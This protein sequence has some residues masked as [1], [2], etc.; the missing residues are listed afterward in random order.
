MLSDNLRKLR[1]MGL[2]ERI[3]TNQKI[4][5][6]LVLLPVFLL[7]RLLDLWLFPGLRLP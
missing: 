4:T 5:V 1:S 3:K 7:I 6:R 2:I